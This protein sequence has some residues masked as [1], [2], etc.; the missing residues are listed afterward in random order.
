[1]Y[2]QNKEWFYISNWLTCSNWMKLS[3]V[4]VSVDYETVPHMRAKDIKTLTLFT[5]AFITCQVNYAA[6]VS[7]RSGDP[8]IG[9]RDS[10]NHVMQCV[11]SLQ[12]LKIWDTT[13]INI[14]ISTT[15]FNIT[16]IFTEYDTI[17]WCFCTKKILTLSRHLQGRAVWPRCRCLSPHPH[18]SQEVLEPPCPHLWRSHIRCKCS[19]SQGM[20]CQSPHFAAEA[21][22][23]KCYKTVIDQ[24]RR[25]THDPTSKYFTVIL[26]VE[27]SKTCCSFKI[28]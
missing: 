21:N 2:S 5:L 20:H 8:N 6:A 15:I 25:S 3:V 28:A 23:V 13:R 12:D 11:S 9:N 10:D 27:P 26:T 22:K 7:S 4:C 24:Q 14:A 19:Q 17:L 16:H 18:A 1:M